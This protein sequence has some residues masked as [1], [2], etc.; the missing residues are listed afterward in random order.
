MAYVVPR[1]HKPA[2]LGRVLDI[3][4]PTAALVFCRTRV[5]VDQLTDTLI[6]RGYRAEA[7]HGGM[8]QEQRDKVMSRLRSGAAELL[9]ATDVA[10]RG[11]DVDVLTHV[12]NY[13]V[14]SAPESYVHRI[15]RV[16]R[17]GREGVAITLAEP[18][19]RRLLGNI[20][21]L[22][23]QPI[24]VE[25]VPSVADLRARQME[26]TISALRVALEADAEALD[27]FRTAVRSLRSE[28]DELDLAAAAL[29][30]VHEANGST[31][32]EPEIP[33]LSAP[34]PDRWDRSE[35]ADRSDRPRRGEP[36]DG[37][38]TGKLYIALGK[39][40]RIR[41]ADLVGAIANE[42]HLSGKQIGPIFV[43]EKYSVVGVPEG[44]VDTV[45]AALQRST[46]KGKRPD[47]R[48]F[49]EGGGPPRQQHRPFDRK[50]RKGPGKH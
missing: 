22:T 10:A 46:I 29:R 15:G 38:P 6:A 44:D 32:E 27:P 47:I 41:P 2:A 21:R 11:L 45:I 3:E 39:H 37:G 50:H 35:R 48:R 12:V 20:E 33:D 17:A 9:I 7:L 26:L 34:K 24:A 25:P 23:G 31:A 19:E 43:A 36:G 30:L 42:T 8:S 16:G 14:P 28:Y 40:H 1:A 18:R 5:E 49:V 4:A 13:D